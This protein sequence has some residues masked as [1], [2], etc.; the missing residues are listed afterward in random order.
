MVPPLIKLQGHRLPLRIR[1]SHCC[2]P[3]LKNR[4]QKQRMWHQSVL[5]AV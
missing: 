4:N 3:D 1:P 2:K 5:L